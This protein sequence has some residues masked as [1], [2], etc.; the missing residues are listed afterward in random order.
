MCQL[1]RIAHKVVPQEIN[2]CSLI[3]QPW[4]LMRSTLWWVRVLCTHYTILSAHVRRVEVARP[5]NKVLNVG[6]RWH[7][8]KYT[9]YD[10]NTESWALK[11]ATPED[12][13]S[14]VPCYKVLKTQASDTF[15]EEFKSMQST[16]FRML[17]TKGVS[18]CELRVYS[19]IQGG[20]ASHM[21]NLQM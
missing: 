18:R 1:Y 7:L 6:A 13:K 5:H 21:R 17:L 11:W 10:L 8:Q 14:H 4:I 9:L 20:C 2:S 12:Y 19:W 3:L 15:K 16:R